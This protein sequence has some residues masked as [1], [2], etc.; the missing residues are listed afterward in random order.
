MKTIFFGTP[1]FS[2]PAL[3]TLAKGSELCLVVTQE[4]KKRGR[5]KNVTPSP[6]KTKALELGVEVF[7]PS[8]INSPESLEKLKSYS[9]DVFVVVAYGQILKKDILDIPKIDIINIHAS[10]LPKLRGAAPIQFS[11]LEGHSETGVCIMRIEEG[12][13]SGPVALCK[14]MAIGERDYGEVSAELSKL[15]AQALDEYLSL[16]KRNEVSFKRQDHSSSSYAPKIENELL[17]LDP[18]EEE[19][20]YLQRKVRAFSPNLGAKIMLAGETLKVYKVNLANEMEL[21]PGQYK[22]V[23]KNLYLG[24]KKGALSIE[25]LQR[26][27]KKRM[28]IS[29]FLAGYNLEKNGYVDTLER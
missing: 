21:E 28:D 6:V 3:E 4:D 12:L 5:G 11:I 24:C 2:V 25:N 29:S 20:L 15:G 19:A 9:A 8:N 22:V 7:Q 14:K 10:I 27:G 18:Y 23:S 1:G 26:P 17:W 16:L 13:D